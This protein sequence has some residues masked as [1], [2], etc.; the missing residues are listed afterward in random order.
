MSYAVL[1]VVVHVASIRIVVK[2]SVF[3]FSCR[4]SS[5]KGLWQY[6][7]CGQQSGRP[8][9]ISHQGLLIFDLYREK[10]FYFYTF[11]ST[12]GHLTPYEELFSHGYHYYTSTLSIIYHCF[13][14]KSYSRFAEFIIL[15]FGGGPLILSNSSLFSEFFIYK[16]IMFSKFVNISSLSVVIKRIISENLSCDP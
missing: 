5:I 1:Q 10:D 12:R 7:S 4:K 16:F 3:I 15:L 9:L 13:H 8:I 14:F 6:S 11:T 2:T